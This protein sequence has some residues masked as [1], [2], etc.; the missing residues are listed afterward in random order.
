MDGVGETEAV[1]QSGV[2]LLLLCPRCYDVVSDVMVEQGRWVV[3]EYAQTVVC[4]CDSWKMV[5]LVLGF[6]LEA[7]S[8]GFLL[9]R[10]RRAGVSDL[11]FDAVSG[12]ML[13][14]SD[15]FNSNGFA[16]QIILE[17]RKAAD[18]RWSRVE[19]G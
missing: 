1:T 7:D 3:H 10:H 2:S 6:W 11:E 9:R 8:Y 5:Y 12:D 14:R 19:L 16:S 17:V 4:A 13:P 18:Q 15:S